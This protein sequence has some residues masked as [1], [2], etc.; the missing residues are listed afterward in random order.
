MDPLLG[1]LCILTGLVILGISFR[2]PTNMP[3]FP[4]VFSTLTSLFLLGRGWTLI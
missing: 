1:S 3:L 4:R 2:N